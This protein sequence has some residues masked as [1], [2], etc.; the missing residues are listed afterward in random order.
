MAAVLVA[1][2]LQNEKVEEPVLQLVGERTGLA[3]TV[4]ITNVRVDKTADVACWPNVY[5]QARQLGNAPFFC[6]SY[7]TAFRVHRLGA[8]GRIPVD[9]L[10]LDGFDGVFANI[11]GHCTL[12]NVEIELTANG[13]WLVYKPGVTTITPHRYLEASTVRRPEYALV[14]AGEA[15]EVL[16]TAPAAAGRFGRMINRRRGGSHA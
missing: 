6:P 8:D 9:A 10:H 12:A 5:A 16:V 7:I 14:G 4:T 1:K 2:P 3:G 11:L 13:I 15:D